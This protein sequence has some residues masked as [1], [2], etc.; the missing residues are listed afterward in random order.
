MANETH[1]IPYSGATIDYAMTWAVEN[2]GYS[3]ETMQDEIEG[4]EID[5][6][7]VIQD[8]DSVTLTIRQEDYEAKS[9]SLPLATPFKPGLMSPVDKIKLN[10]NSTPTEG[11]GNGVTSGGVYTAIEDAKAY[12]IGRIPKMVTLTS[13]EYQALVDAGTVDEYTYY[14]I[15]ENTPT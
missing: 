10:F 14:F 12:C 5:L 2:M 3:L 15:A 9:V 11:S 8:N 6:F 13:A 4:L 1:V 7:S